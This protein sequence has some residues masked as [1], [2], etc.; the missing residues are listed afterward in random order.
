VGFAMSPPQFLQPGDV[1]ETR[2]DRIGTIT[3]RIVAG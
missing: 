2:I 1:V 3:N